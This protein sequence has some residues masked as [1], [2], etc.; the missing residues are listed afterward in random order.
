MR[1][2]LRA[3]LLPVPLVAREHDAQPGLTLSRCCDDDAEL[4]VGVIDDVAD[5]HTLA[6]R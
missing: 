3:R 6:V 5:Y 4:V 2:P 1:L